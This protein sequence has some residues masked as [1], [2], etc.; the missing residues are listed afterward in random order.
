MLPNN[1][2]E[3]KARAEALNLSL[4]KLARRRHIDP[5]TVYRA[6]R[7]EGDNRS[8]TVTG[9]AEEIVAEEISQRDRL[10]ALHPLAEPGE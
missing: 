9:L 3:I 5:S 6:A 7:G 4:K 10:L 8:K 1:I 2:S